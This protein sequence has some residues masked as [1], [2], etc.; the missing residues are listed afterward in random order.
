M[1]GV[2]GEVWHVD[3]NRSTASVMAQVEYKS[4]VLRSLSVTGSTI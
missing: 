2:E 1:R 4:V 3:G